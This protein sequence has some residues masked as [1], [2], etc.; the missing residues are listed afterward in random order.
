GGILA[1]HPLQH[2]PRRIRAPQLEQAPPLGDQSGE[3]AGVLLQARLED[4]Q[5]L[6]EAPQVPVLLGELEEDPRG[7]IGRPAGARPGQAGRE[8]EVAHRHAPRRRSW[9]RGERSGAVAGFGKVAALYSSHWPYRLYGSGL[10]VRR[11][12]RAPGTYWPVVKVT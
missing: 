2:L 4:R 1:H 5:G 6:V 8:L 10:G 11:A 3:V 9:R 12:P 7:G